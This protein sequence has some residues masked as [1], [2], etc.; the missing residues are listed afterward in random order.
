M[1]QTEGNDSKGN[2]TVMR[3]GW[4]GMLDTFPEIIF[5][6]SVL[7]SEVTHEHPYATV[8]SAVMSLMVRKLIDYEVNQSL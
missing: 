3:A 8:C 2:G 4:L 1:R 6:L 5:G 7:Q